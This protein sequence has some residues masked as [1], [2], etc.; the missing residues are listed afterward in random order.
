MSASRRRTWTRVVRRVL[1]SAGL[2]LAPAVAP[3]VA[4]AQRRGGGRGGVQ[5]EPNVP[6]D[7]RLTWVRV[8]YEIADF[9]GGMGFRGAPPWTH[10]YPRG[11]RHFMKIISELSTTRTRTQESNVLTLDDPQLGKFPIALMAEPGFWR[12]SDAEVLGL[13]NYLLKGGFI[14]FDDFTPRD[15]INLTQ[16][17]AKVFPKLR[18]VQLTLQHPIFDSFYRIKTLEYFHPMYGGA[19]AWYGWFEDNDP[20]KRLLAVADYNNDLSEYWEFS[21]T[22]MFP[23]DLSNDAYKIG[24][25]YVIYALTR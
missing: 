24:V 11:E 3:M 7:G 16:Q 1:T 10:D 21:D 9:S 2:L 13:R 14:I 17:M 18:P 20:T 22:G 23:I 5:I 4:D 25:N 12:P 15:W 6:Y 19:S 8:R